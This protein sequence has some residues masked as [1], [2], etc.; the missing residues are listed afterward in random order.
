MKIISAQEKEK[1]IS[2]CFIKRHIS[3]RKCDFPYYKRVT[4]ALQLDMVVC[5]VTAS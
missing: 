5:V 4:V 3:E 1:V 2:A